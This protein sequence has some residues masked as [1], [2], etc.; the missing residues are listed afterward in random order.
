MS[1]QAS[2]ARSFCAWVIAFEYYDGPMAGI[3]LRNRDRMNVFFRAIGW[4]EEQWNRVFAVTPVRGDSVE[5]LRS[6]LIR[7]E[8]PK[9]P[10]WLP[11]S[12]TN[13]PEVTSAWEA[14][15][16]DTRESKAWS[17][18]ESHNLLSTANETVLPSELVSAVTQLVAKGL[19]RDIAG[20]A[21]LV[22]AL[23]DQLHGE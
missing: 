15:L 12:A 17:L 23:L 13:T 22:P 3:G 18:V 9:E 11:S 6:A 19:V 5:S 1:T 16:A 7:I 10:F 4:D 14:L 20:A 8:V 2:S 21:P